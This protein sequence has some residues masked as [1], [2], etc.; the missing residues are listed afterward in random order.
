MRALFKH[1]LRAYLNS[2]AAYAVT[3]LFLAIS[4][5]YY[6]LD[7]LRGRNVD[8]SALYSTMGTLFLFIV[9]IMTSRIIAEEKRS[10]VQMLLLTAPIKIEGIVAG[11]FFAILTLITL[12]LALTLLFPLFLLLFTPLHPLSLIG[13]Y[14][15]LLLLGASICAFG[16]FASSLTENQVIAAIISFVTLLLL[17]IMRPIG[18]AMGGNAAKALAFISPF[19][20]CDEIARGIFSLQSVLYFLS[21]AFGF[22]FLT[23]YAV[24]E[25][26]QKSGK[27]AY[28]ALSIA[29][30]LA[31]IVLVNLIAGLYPVKADLSAGRRYSVGGATKELLT[32]LD[33]NI[34]IYGLFDDGKGDADYIE[35]REL[36]EK[37]EKLSNKRV[38][39]E[40]IDPDRDL[41]VIARLD[42][43]NE[44]G[45][46]KND[47]FVTDNKNGI[48]L[49][50]QNLFLMEYD[51]KTSAWF[52]TGSG[53]EKAF[54]G[55]IQTLAG[56]GGA[57][58]HTGDGYTLLSYGGETVLPQFGKTYSNLTLEVEESEIIPLEF[59]GFYLPAAKEFDAPPGSVVLAQ[60][61]G[62][63]ALAAAWE[64]D[65]A[66]Y[67]LIGSGDF[68][69][70]AVKI[71]HPANYPT[72]QYF[73]DSALEWVGAAATSVA[74]EV[75]DYRAGELQIPRYKANYIGFLTIIVAPFAIF[76]RG[77]IVWRRRRYL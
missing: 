21:F 63:K 3:G 6:T 1:E 75:K 57:S 64:T 65:G 29:S 52:K 76:L 30:I 10:G 66:R 16:L 15:G 53:A 12:M 51:V 43:D 24:G 49:G 25:G 31:I 39:V 13:N 7:N 58:A 74:V 47:F 33:R 45:L 2:P 72:N 20:R 40:Y 46:R 14:A 22:L 61:P 36:L 35:V 19:S 37:Y 34:T 60:S 5:V 11:K 9:P 71:N 38:K 27:N 42:P 17:L 62:G 48:K 77:L 56:S 26:R 69:S 18:A 67:V 32:E 73:Q 50:Y 23:V 55:A 8:L 4:A 54:S 28:A 70:D 44:Y 68:L 59:Y 41:N